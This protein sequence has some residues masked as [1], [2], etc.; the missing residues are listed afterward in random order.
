MKNRRDVCAATEAGYIQYE[1]LMGAIKTGCQLSPLQNSKFCYYHAPRT[2]K[3][4]HCD[5]EKNMGIEESSCDEGIV[6]RKSLGATH[7]IR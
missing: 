6:G 5:P 7:I 2:C 1:D 3:E 4:L